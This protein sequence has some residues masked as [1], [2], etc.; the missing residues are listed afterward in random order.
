MLAEMAS[1][2]ARLRQWHPIER[3]RTLVRHRKHGRAEF[4]PALDVR[5]TRDGWTVSMD[6]PGLDPKDV[7]VSLEADMLRISG[8]R[9][10]AHDEDAD[11]FHLRERSFGTFMRAFVL[12]PEADR[13]RLHADLNAGVLVISIPRLPQYQPQRIETR[14]V[15]RDPEVRSRHHR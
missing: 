2:P 10:E 12:P 8:A 5:A 4:L 13:E 14:D 7:H 6:L 15:E 1:V 3:L 11:R 9:K